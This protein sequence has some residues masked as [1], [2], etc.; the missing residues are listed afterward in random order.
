MC[1]H[2][3]AGDYLPKIQSVLFLSSPYQRDSDVTKLVKICIR[4]MRISTFKICGMRMRI[5]AFIL[6]VG[7]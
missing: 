3:F 4:R 1:F 5:V 7:T 6:S 2:A